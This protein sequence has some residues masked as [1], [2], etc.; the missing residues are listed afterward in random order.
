MRL[1]ISKSKNSTLFYIIKD[2]TKNKKRSTKIFKRIGNLEEVK[3]MAGNKD[4]KEWLKDYVKKYNEEHCKSETIIIKK[5]NQKIISMDNKTS[6]NVGY[7]FLKSIYSKLNLNDIC[8][9][10]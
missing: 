2:Y 10:I 3:I 6:F 5:N 8:N 4:Y 7:L 9:Q 1:K